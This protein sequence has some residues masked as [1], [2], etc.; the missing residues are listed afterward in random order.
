MCVCKQQARSISTQSI[1]SGLQ[2]AL[3]VVYC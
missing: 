3:T 1:P 2:V